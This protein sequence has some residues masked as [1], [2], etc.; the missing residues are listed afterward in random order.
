MTP[1]DRRMVSPSGTTQIEAPRSRRGRIRVDRTAA[2]HAR[3]AE[4]RIGSLAWIFSLQPPA[5]ADGTGT[6]LGSG[7]QSAS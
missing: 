4:E 5:P 1:L 7:G 2:D 3:F 6:R